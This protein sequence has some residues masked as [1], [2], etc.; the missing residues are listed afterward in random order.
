V[1]KVQFDL[2][3]GSAEMVSKMN[4]PYTNF[5][6]K[7]KQIKRELMNAFENVLDSG[8]YI[9]GPEVKEFELDFASYS[10]TKFAAGISN[11]TCSLKLT[12]QALDLPSDSEVIT[13]PNSFIA[14]AASIVL[15]GL[16]PAFVD[17]GEDMN[18]D[19]DLL[20]AAINEKTKVIMPVH[21]TGRPAKMD[22]IM[23]LAEKYNL[24]VLEDAAQAVG[25]KFKGQRVGSFGTAGSFSLHPLK[26][27][28]AY[29]DAGVVTT[30]DEKLWT[31]LSLLKNHGLSDR[32]TCETFSSNCRLDELQASFLRIQLRKLDEWN[33]ARR[34]LANNYNTAL[35]DV[36]SVPLEN[37]HEFHVYQTYMIK[38]HRRDELQSF[39]RTQGIESIIHYPIPIHLQP[40]AKSL[41]HKEGSFPIAEKLSQEIL[42]LPLYPGLSQSDQQF[43]IEKIHEFYK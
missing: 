38:A 16:K 13:A 37:E 33:E 19:V 32:I 26:N 30:N 28:H 2:E 23:F 17:A 41:N 24:Y 43:V 6:P 39:L 14:S 10:G 40:A 22:K 3:K 31:K 25:A 36:V 5:A 4:V 18:M 20:E 8:R 34:S 11:G 27:L 1:S 9:Q 15:A 7:N 29:G 35:A 21:L 42:S 12:L